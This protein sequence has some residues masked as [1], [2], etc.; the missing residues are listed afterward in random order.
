MSEAQGCSLGCG[1]PITAEQIDD[2]EAVYREVT[3]WVHGPKLQGPVLRTQTGRLA[4][5]ECIN[6]LIEGQSPD[7]QSIPGLEG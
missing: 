1:K 5:R 6:K 7:Q 4:H 3:S 2:P